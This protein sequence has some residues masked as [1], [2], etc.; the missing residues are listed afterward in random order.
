M[1]DLT[2]ELTDSLNIGEDKGLNLPLM[3][4]LTDTMCISGVVSTLLNLLISLTDS[5][6]AGESEVNTLPLIEYL[7]DALI[8]MRDEVILSN[9]RNSSGVA[10]NTLTP[11]YGLEWTGK[12]VGKK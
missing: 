5:I 7:I 4:V 1:A 3:P 8:T 10:V 2:V 12:G 9:T 11:G 6:T